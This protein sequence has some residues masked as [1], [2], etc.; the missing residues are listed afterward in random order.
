MS[1]ETRRYLE[2][3]ADTE[4]A[5]QEAVRREAGWQGLAACRDHDVNEFYMVE[6]EN[7]SS[8][9]RRVWAAK[10]VCAGCIVKSECLEKA[11]K[12]GEHGVWGDTTEGERMDIKR[13]RL[14]KR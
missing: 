8:W 12:N 14:V 13:R 3:R 2:L 7:L 1:A 5:E 11:L 10:Q 6:R 9:K 4:L